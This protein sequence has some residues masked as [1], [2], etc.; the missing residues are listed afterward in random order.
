M[1]NEEQPRKLEIFLVAYCLQP[2]HTVEFQP[3]PVDQGA[4][5]KDVHKH[6]ENQSQ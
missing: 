4:I 2:Q 5:Y 6:R 3:E 1:S